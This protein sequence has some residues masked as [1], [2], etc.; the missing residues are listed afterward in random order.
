MLAQ[1]AISVSWAFE[2]WNSALRCWGQEE[3][4]KPQI[5]LGFALFTLVS[6]VMLYRQF[7]HPLSG[8]PGPFFARFTGL[9]RNWQYYK[10]NWHDKVLEIHQTYGRVVRIAPNELSVV[11]EK[12]LKSLYAHGH[13]TE[14]TDWYATWEIPNTAPGL[15]ATRDRNLHSFLRKR[16]SGTYSMTAVLK[17]ETFIQGCFD[18]LFQKLKEHSGEVIDMAEWTNAAAYDIVGELGYGERLGHLESETDVMGVRQAILDGFF[19]M[20]NLGHVWGQGMII[21][22]P[23][24]AKLTGMFG[25]A[26]PFNKFQNWSIERVTHRRNHPKHDRHDMLNHFLQMKDATGSPVGEGEVLIEAM[27]IVYGI[28][29]EHRL[30]SS[31]WMC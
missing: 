1:C 9:W 19:M 21:N 17:F 29:A 7:F 31:I 14:K 4:S 20:G 3:V 22:N 12:A 2:K 6:L 28:P 8:I 18:I 10:G 25:I 27:N 15:F 30:N 24:V 13:N 16:V 11:D 5:S 23:V 26:N